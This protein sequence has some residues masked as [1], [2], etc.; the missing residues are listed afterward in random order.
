MWLLDFP[1]RCKHRDTSI[2]CVPYY[3]VY[4]ANS[5]LALQCLA[6]FKSNFNFYGTI[7]YNL[8]FFFSFSRQNGQN[9]CSLNSFMKS[10][11]L[12]KGKKWGSDSSYT[13][14]TDI[15]CCVKYIKHGCSGG[16][17]V[18]VL[19]TLNVSSE[20]PVFWSPPLQTAFK[21]VSECCSGH[22]VFGWYGLALT[23]MA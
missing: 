11:D 17:A 23:L 21:Q 19:A 3:H 20:V 1:T 2:W 13:T 18:L 8:E 16:H 4:P 10:T 22:F 12:N 6:I 15:L 14:K 7:S 9:S 5:S